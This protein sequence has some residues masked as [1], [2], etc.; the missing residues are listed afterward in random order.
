MKEINIVSY[1]GGQ[2]S[3]A[4]IIEMVARKMPI[5]EI[6]FCDVG[7]EM[8]ETYT[9]LK[10]FEDWC[11]KKGLKFTQIE[12]NLGTIKDYY[13]EKKLIPYR[14]FRHCTDKF[15]VRPMNDYIKKVYGIKTPINMFM[16]I[17]NDEKHRSEKIRGRKQFTHLFPLIE[18][19]LD[20]LGCVEIIKKEGLSVPVKSGC[21]FCPFQPKR[22]W[23]DLYKI[24]PELF[25][26]SINFEK[27]ANAYP[28]ATLMGKVKLEDFRKA[29]AEQTDLS[30]F[31]EDLSLGQCA[32]CHT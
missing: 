13:L 21:Y 32:Y 20:R 2:N 24:H 25:Q 12:S 4:M 23:I 1:G 26:D 7:N 19:E 18:W 14:M 3:T 10:E 17:A 27:N 6:I 30:D 15:K 28:N 11:S 16:G 22:A 29:L 5:N 9:F 31:K 8:P